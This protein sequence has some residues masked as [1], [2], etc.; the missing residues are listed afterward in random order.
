M[1]RP[2]HL[3]SD[4][5][6]MRKLTV[7]IRQICYALS[8]TQNIYDNP[9]FFQEYSRMDRSL[10]G[11]EGAPEWPSLRSMLPDLQGARILDLGC[12][13]GWFS[14]WA[15]E[16]GAQSVFGFDV[17]ENM[18]QRAIE[19]TSDNAVVYRRLDLEQI[20][21]PGGRF[22]L[23]FSSLVLHY[24][25]N[26]SRVCR[27]VY[28]ALAPGG[29]FIFSTEH[30]IYTAPRRPEWL[31][32]NEGC[33]TWP[34]DQYLAEGSRVTDWLTKGVIKE[35]RTIGTI[36]NLLAQSGFA[37]THLDEWGPTEDQIAAHPEWAE[38]R[39]R[40]MFLLVSARKQVEAPALTS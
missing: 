31:V 30:P 34:V 38:H 16:Q 1:R 8:M 20:E 3:P 37:L 33:R 12:G 13:F 40:P 6:I 26:L 14:R 23:V 10:Q 4:P 29:S 36:V 25:E 15:R 5:A 24:V 18:L 11:L 27:S 39:E 19:M 7:A 17:S 28:R 9:D 35:H 21:L 2:L 32:Q 22:E